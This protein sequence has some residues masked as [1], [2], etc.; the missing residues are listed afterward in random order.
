LADFPNPNEAGNF[1]VI[2]KRMNEAGDRY[3]LGCWWKLFHERFWQI[4]GMEN[5]M[6]D[7][8]DEMDKLKML[9]KRFLEYYK[10]IIDKFAA[11]G[12][13][14]IF[15]SDDLGHQQGPM[16]SPKIFKDLYFP[17]YKSIL[18]FGITISYKSSYSE[19]LN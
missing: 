17:L 4:R 11:L 1:D 19:N 2:E 5:L 13:N 6:L 12:F 18:S 15:S 10:V 14:G 8:Y 16:M 9:G 7:Y 3:K